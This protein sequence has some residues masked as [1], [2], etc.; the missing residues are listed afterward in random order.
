MGLSSARLRRARQRSMFVAVAAASFLLVSAAHA[1][2]GAYRGVVMADAP[3]AYWRLGEASGTAAVDQTGT[4]PGIYSGGVTRAQAGA[5]VGDADTAVR[6]DGSSGY[7]AVRDSASLAVGDEFSLEV[8][9]KRASFGSDQRIFHKG[10]GWAVLQFTE[11]NT[12]RFAKSGSGDITHSTQAVTDTTSWHHIVATK[13][14]ASVHLYLDG[15]EVTGSVVAQTIENTTS[16]LDIGRDLSGVQEL[17]ASA[18]EA[19]LY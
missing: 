17:N 7:I 19:A 11:D 2:N 5:L 6:L 3:V 15:E 8:W 1:D 13:D 12:I 14:G 18:D 16:L 10:T 9:V 4:N